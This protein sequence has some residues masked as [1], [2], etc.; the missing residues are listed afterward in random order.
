MIAGVVGHALERDAVLLEHGVVTVLEAF[1]V[2][3]APQ[4]ALPAAHLAQPPKEDLRGARTDRRREADHAERAARAVAHR[5]RD[6]EFHPER[7]AI[8]ELGPVEGDVLLQFAR[9]AEA[10][11]RVGDL[12][13][14]VF[15][16]VLHRVRIAVEI[17][18][19]H[20][21]DHVLDRVPVVGLPRGLAHEV[22]PLGIGELGRR[23]ER[24][25]VFASRRGKVGEDRVGELAHGIRAQREAAFDR[26]ARQR[27]N[28]CDAPVAVDLDAVVRAGDRVAHHAPLREPR[29]TM[30]ATKLLP[31]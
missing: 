31:L 10:V 25:R 2:E 14:V 24:N 11:G 28:R 4:I 8:A 23:H 12:H 18:A 27:R 7:A 16:T 9:D 29:A 13:D 30:R 17:R 3:K 1:A 19:V 22:R 15:R 26:A 21:I 6:V 20:R 5:I